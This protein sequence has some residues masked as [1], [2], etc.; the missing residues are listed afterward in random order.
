MMSVQETNNQINHVFRPKTPSED[1]MKAVFQF[2]R[3]NKWTNVLNSCRSNPLIPVTNMVMQNNITT[4]ILHQAITSKGDTKKR[5]IIIQEILNVTPNAATIRNGYGSLPL[6][7]IAQRNTKM[8]SATKEML[9]RKLIDA[10][11]IA[12]TQQGGVS[13]RTPL[14][15]I[16]TDYVSPRLTEA[17]IQIGKKSCFLVD[18]KG[19]LPAHVACSR[20]CSPEKLDMLL[21]I[22]PNSLFAITNSGDTLLS[23]AKKTAT[24]SHPNY[25]LIDVIKRK[26]GLAVIP[27]VSLD[28]P[29]DVHS[30]CVSRTD[31]SNHDHVFKESERS[32]T[33]V[34]T[35]GCSSEPVTRRKRKRKVTSDGKGNDTAVKQ[36]DI[37]QAILLLNVSRHIDEEARGKIAHV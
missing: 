36:E 7:V 9:V 22:N 17:M 20:H 1:E 30:A 27:S 29:Y 19:Y 25:A 8:D 6:H 26:I 10:Y 28:I 32:K 23:L 34:V 12:L 3:A 33:S 5:A 13:K 4:T 16:F 11:P 21:K 2:C 35:I 18:K 37:E 24:K 31:S 14:H 15:V